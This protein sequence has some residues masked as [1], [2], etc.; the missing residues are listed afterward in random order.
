MKPRSLRVTILLMGLSSLPGFAAG[1]S[2]RLAA[3]YL[4]TREKAWFV[5]PN[6]ISYTG[7]PC[8]SCHTGI[9]YLL[10]RPLL[11]SALGE[12]RPTS[13]ERDLVSG[14]RARVDITEPG[15]FS[16]NPKFPENPRA[17]RFISAESIFAALF[18]TLDSPGSPETERAF[19]RMWSLQV[20]DGADKGAWKWL[21]TFGDPSSNPQATFFGAS[22]ATL[23]VANTSAEYRNRADV[24]AHVAMLAAY[25]EKERGNQPLFSRLALL[26]TSAKLPGILPDSARRSLIAE[27]LRK[28]EADGGWTMESLGPWAEHPQAPATTGSSSYATGFA[29]FALQKG[30]VERSDPALNRALDWLRAHQDREGGYWAAESM[31]KP[32]DPGTMMVQFARDTATA[33]AALA[34][35]ESGDTGK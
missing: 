20:Q 13:W 12:T 19:K 18:L 8:I 22:L 32:Y 11:R 5:W 29:A 23:A 25:L 9:P 6:A 30:G 26:W 31:N 34:L 33:F 7:G 14:I 35:L 16:K 17:E 24:R 2:P 21:V 4:D 27:A 10:V 1:W 15:P 28:Q 3:D